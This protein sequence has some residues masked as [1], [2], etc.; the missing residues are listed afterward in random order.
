[1]VLIGGSVSQRN[2]TEQPSQGGLE[3]SNHYADIANK[4]WLNTKKL[5]NVK[6]NVV[7]QEIWD[8]LEKDDFDYGSLLLLENLQILER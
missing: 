3:S 5:G 8:H 7:K 1:M 2:N 6:A 4:H